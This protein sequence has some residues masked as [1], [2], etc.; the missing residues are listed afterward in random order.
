MTAEVIISVKGVE[1]NGDNEGQ[2]PQ[3]WQMRW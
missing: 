1:E 3:L 2:Q